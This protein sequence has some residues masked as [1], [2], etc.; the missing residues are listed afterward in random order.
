MD[1]TDQEFEFAEATNEIEEK[2]IEDTKRS[3]RLTIPANS[4]KSVSFMIRPKK[5]GHIAIKIKAVTPISGD[6]IEQMLPVEPEGVT[7]YINKAIFINLKDNEH[8]EKITIDIPD[9]AVPDSQYVEVSV[10]G[11]LLGPTIKNLDKLIRMPY[12]CGEQNMVNFVPNILVMKYLTKIN[13]L[14]PAIETKAKKYMEVGYQ[15]ELTYKHADGSYSAFGENPGWG[16][17]GKVNGSTW[18]TAYVVKSFHQAIPY[19]DIDPKVIDQGL[20]FLAGVQAPDGRFPE[21]GRVLDKAYSGESENGISLTSYVL[22]AFLENVESRGKYEENIKKAIN[23]LNENI[24]KVGNDIY[25][26]AITAYALKLADSPSA[27]KV[28][29]KL[30]AMARTEGDRKWWAKPEDKNEKKKI[31]NLVIG[32]DLK[33]LMLNKLHML[34]QQFFWIVEKQKILYQF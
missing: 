20:S 11:D 30:K 19:T 29:E 3:K 25:A 15:K 28:S 1:N 16:D 2:S 21:Y 27:E 12:G 5:V 4:G 7:Q 34:Y 26:T 31:K 23:Y 9:E 24:D 10:V 6:A 8:S 33:V 22:L 14:T 32:I 17:S 13:Q 18:L